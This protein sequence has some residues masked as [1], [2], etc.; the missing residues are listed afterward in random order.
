MSLF[1]FREFDVIQSR[2]AMKVGTDAM[3]LGSLLIAENCENALDIGTGTGVLSLMLAQRNQ[4]IQIVAVEIDRDSFEECQSNFQRSPWQKRLSVKHMDFRL[5]KSDRRYDL[6]LSNP[7]Y[8]Q[9]RYENTNARAAQARHE[10]HLPMSAFVQGCAALLSDAG[11][12]SIILPKED[13]QKWVGEFEQYALH[14]IRKVDLSGKRGDAPRRVV[15]DFG[16]TKCAL[17][18]STLVIRETDGSYSPEYK[19]LTAAY[20]ANAI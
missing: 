2:S 6:I 10:R 16:R 15:L 4:D 12:V 8:F 9:S 5:F 13:E 17:D 3:I 11:R 18:P 7:P 14:V 20:H 19:K 1:K